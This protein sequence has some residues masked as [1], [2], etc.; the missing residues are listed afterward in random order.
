[1]SES[2][3]SVITTDLEGRIQ[4][5]N[6][7]AELLF[8][9][10][11]A[12][13]IGKRRVSIFSPGEI[14]LEHV[15]R[16]LK[17]ASEKGEFRTRTV[18][19]RK[20]GSQFAAEIRI[21]PT[22]KDGRQIG[23]CGVTTPLNEVPPQEAYPPIRWATK[24]FRWLVVTRA[25]FLTASVMPILIGAAWAMASRGL[26]PFP[27]MLFALV[28]VGGIAMHIAANTF[29]DY[30]DWRSGTDQENND[31]FLPY[32]G[33]SRSLEL[34]LISEPGL[35]RLA[36]AALGIAILCGVLLIILQGAMIALFGIFGAFSVYFYTAPPLRLVARKGLGELLIGLNF[37]PLMVAGT[38]FALT[39]TLH[40]LDF[41]IGMPIGFLVTA[42]LWINEFPDREADALTG[43]NHLVVVLGKQKARW[44]YL[45]LVGAAFLWVAWG[46]LTG[47]FP[48]GALV[49]LLALPM[50]ISAVRVLFKHYA[51]RALVTANV[52]T[53]KLHTMAGVLLALGIFISPYLNRLLGG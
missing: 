47:L 3:K 51:D 32:S 38:A 6:K 43:K 13:V 35:F 10:T 48:P 14:V 42:I 39:G 19:K 27:W 41:F 2:V 11:P 22:F 7:G 26:S 49:I 8:G 4:T 31:Y 40:W 25:P 44:G 17:E 45:A 29:N 20:D 5:F 16:W 30:F 12:E 53:I 21:T 37:G 28:L 52:T 23:F 46:A 9:Y 36:W 18:F 24:A 15:P 1:M 34:G 50:A 33:G